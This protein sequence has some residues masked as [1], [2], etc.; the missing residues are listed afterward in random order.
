MS[1]S[2]D[3][4]VCFQLGNARARYTPPPGRGTL[5]CLPITK[6]SR[7]NY[8][9]IVLEGPSFSKL[10]NKQLY[11]RLAKGHIIDGRKRITYA[12]QTESVTNPNIKNLILEENTLN[13]PEPEPPP[14]PP[15]SPPGPTP[16]CFPPGESDGSAVVFDY[17]SNPKGISIY[18]TV[19]G[20]ESYLNSI[21]AYG[22]HQSIF[23]L[24]LT[25]PYSSYYG[26][27]EPGEGIYPMPGK[28]SSYI[29]QIESHQPP[30]LSSLPHKI[31]LSCTYLG[32]AINI[33]DV[34]GSSSS[35]GAFQ[36]HFKFYASSPTI[37]DIESA[38]LLY[39]ES[40]HYSI[41]IYEWYSDNSPK[42]IQILHGGTDT[43]PNKIWDLSGISNLEITFIYSK[44]IDGSQNPLPGATGDN[45]IGNSF[46]ITNFV[47]IAS[48]NTYIFLE[49]LY[50]GAP[51]T[52]TISGGIVDHVAFNSFI[53]ILQILPTNAVPKAICKWQYPMET[54]DISCQFSIHEGDWYTDYSPKNIKLI[55]NATALDPS[56]LDAI[57]DLSGHSSLQ[58]S[59]YGTTGYNTGSVTPLPG[60]HPNVGSCFDILDFIDITTISTSLNVLYNGPVVD[61]SYN[62][63]VG[64]PPQVL[65]YTHPSIFQL[66]PDIIVDLVANPPNPSPPS[67]LIN[68]Y[69]IPNLYEGIEEYRFLAVKLND[70]QKG[71]MD[72]IINNPQKW[73]FKITERPDPIFPAYY[74]S[75]GINEYEQYGL[76]DISENLS[77]EYDVYK[78]LLNTLA[79]PA[80]CAL[81]GECPS[82][83]TPFYT[84][85]HMLN[86]IFLASSDFAPYNPQG[87][88]ADANEAT[89]ALTTKFIFQYKG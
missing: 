42:L 25:T 60:L 43:L 12:S 19:E 51:T 48:D 77:R 23:Y 24:V 15:P 72:P 55:P 28:T 58:L 74:D 68:G 3:A 76:L 80:W 30:Q 71:I 45:E 75:V 56:Y 17:A 89:Q 34:S 11:S 63:G 32:P 53:S 9:N 83:P 36:T 38:L 62:L 70:S 1:Y 27:P 21:Y 66:V 22:L 40:A 73:K 52:W 84:N 6:A 86:T 78:A 7:Q 67:N 44:I 61:W 18:E 54:N 26:E 10:S 31:D 57:W 82:P 37:P 29:L 49:V 79:N 14:P 2:Y 5:L 33:I 65:F 87:A 81:T 39:K 64:P 35:S 69:I 88:Q 16:S 8:K 46:Y 4:S 13:C 41:I 59:A 47:E 85:T 20:G 50:S